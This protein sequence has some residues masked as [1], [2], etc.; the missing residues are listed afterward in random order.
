MIVRTILSA[1]FL[2]AFAACNKAQ[3]PLDGTFHIK[4]ASITV[5]NKTGF[6]SY[7]FIP[8]T[9]NFNLDFHPSGKI[10]GQIGTSKLQGASYK[11][12]KGNTQKNGIEFIV[13]CGTVELLDSSNKTHK[14]KLEL[15]IKHAG[16]YDTLSVEVRQR[17]N[18]DVFPMGDIDL[19]KQ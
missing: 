10:D 14:V 5:R 6:L 3:L 7:Q 8:V 11:K 9:T 4:N 15:W 19:I 16:S 1:I 17:Q 18:L 13:D 2:F 12:N